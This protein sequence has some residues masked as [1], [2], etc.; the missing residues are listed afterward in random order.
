MSASKTRTSATPDPAARKIVYRVSSAS[1][2]LN[3]NKAEVKI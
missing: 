3:N 1:I 2:R